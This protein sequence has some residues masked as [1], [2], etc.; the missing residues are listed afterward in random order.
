[1]IHTEILSHSVFRSLIVKVAVFK[2]T[3]LSVAE[4]I[5]PTSS[6]SFF[7]SP[8]KVS[9]VV[10]LLPAETRDLVS[11]DTNV[12]LNKKFPFGDSEKEKIN[13]HHLH[14]M[15]MQ[16]RVKSTIFDVKRGDGRER[17]APVL[18]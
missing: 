17:H 14:R 15:V 5:S 12:I 6:D 1:M 10:A 9:L 7:C 2:S 18:K 4:T 8:Y 13:S 11:I 3:E 16:L